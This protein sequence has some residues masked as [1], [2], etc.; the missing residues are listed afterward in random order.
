MI[1]YDIKKLEKGLVEGNISE[2]EVFNYLL[3]STLISIVIPYL[4]D[5]NHDNK[6]LTSI[7]LIIDILIM[8]ITLKTTFEINT[9]GDCKDYLKRY[10]SLSLVI[11]IRLVVFLIIPIGIIVITEKI[12]DT[13][14]VIA[15]ESTKDSILFGLSIVAGIIYYFMLTKSFKRVN[16]C[17]K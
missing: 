3:T 17:D 8:I 13:M 15:Y 6:V 11:F 16:K 1:W 4:S 9:K 12:L 14:D 5:R 10:I 7:E 2:K